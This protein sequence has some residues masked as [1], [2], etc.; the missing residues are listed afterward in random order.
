MVA[1]LMLATLACGVLD[2]VTGGGADFRTATELWSDVPRMDGLETSEMDLP[3]AMKTVL[4]FALGNLGLLNGEGEDRTTHNV[5]W[6]VFTSDQEPAAVRNFYTPEL[7]AENGWEDTEE[8]T[9]LDGGDQGLPQVGALCMFAKQVDGV[10][11]YVVIIASD[12]EDS[13]LTNV[14]FFRLETTP[15]PEP[16]G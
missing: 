8:S 5:D 15:T 10:E 1:G 6:I 4:R 7:M 13:G 16:A 14:F 3:V 11:T 2:T 9:C 12:D